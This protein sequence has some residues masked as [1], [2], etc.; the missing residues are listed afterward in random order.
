M[1]FINTEVAVEAVMTWLPHM[2]YTQCL[3]LIPACISCM[4]IIYL[5]IFWLYLPNKKDKS[6]ENSVWAWI[7]TNIYF[8]VFSSTKTRTDLQAK[9]LFSGKKKQWT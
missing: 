3:D 1:S 4:Y 5:F 9:I 2:L 7:A 8:F 6:L